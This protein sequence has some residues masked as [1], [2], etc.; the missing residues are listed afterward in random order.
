M[1]KEAD[2]DVTVRIS[3]LRHTDQT[4]RRLRALASGYRDRCR[5]LIKWATMGPHGLVQQG[6]AERARIVARLREL[7]SE[8]RAEAETHG[9]TV[10]GTVAAV[11]EKTIEGLVSIIE[12]SE[13]P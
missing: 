7:A 5:E 13:E 9:D 12:K 4:I 10:F 3:E 11:Q 1:S 6:A 2:Y 8:L